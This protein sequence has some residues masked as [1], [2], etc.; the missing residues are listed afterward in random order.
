MV[1][2]QRRVG[3]GDEQ[4]SGSPSRRGSGEEGAPAPLGATW[5]E[6]EQAWNFALYSRA[7]SSVT[8]LIYG[9]D[10]VTTPILAELPH[11]PLVHKTG[12][13]WHC[14]VSAARVPG[15][16]YYAYRV[17]GPSG[18]RNRFRAGQ[19]AHRS[20]RASAALPAATSRVRPPG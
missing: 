13:I 10:D 15:A 6:S 3:D 5:V 9:A 2:Q 14:M 16:T 1:R 20:L 17:D 8:L 18:G 7:A 4:R 19:G 12:R 11:D